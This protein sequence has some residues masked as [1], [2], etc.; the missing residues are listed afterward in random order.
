VKHIGLNLTAPAFTHGQF[1]VAIL[2]VKSVSNIKMIW[3]EK[4]REAKS[5]NIV[6]REVLL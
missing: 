5:K 2:R 6:Y 4:E 3:V 1:Y